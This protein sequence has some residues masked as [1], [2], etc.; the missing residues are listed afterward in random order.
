MA[1]R[2]PHAGWEDKRLVSAC[3]R[4]DEEAWGALVEK[5][6]NLVY[7][8]ALRYGAPP[9]DAAD[10]F[11]AVWVDAYSE[12]GKLRKKG[13]VRSW[14]ISVTRNK[15][16]HWKQRERQVAMRMSGGG[17]ELEADPRLAVDPVEIADLERDQLVREALATLPP[18]CRELVRML[19]YEDPPR[20]YRQ[21]AESLGLAIGSIGFIRGRCLQKLQKSLESREIS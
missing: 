6:K 3:L 20:P 18:R 9:A 5:Y 7:A 15:C 13:S 4:G 11:Q 14:L 21:V 12:L 10:L 16:Y 17:E 19:F 2:A 8:I 1:S